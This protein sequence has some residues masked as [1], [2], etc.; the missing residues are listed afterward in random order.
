MKAIDKLSDRHVLALARFVTACE[1]IRGTRRWRAQLADCAQRSNYP[2]FATQTDATSL[3]ELHIR[4]VAFP[5]SLKTQ[6][7]I[8]AGNAVAREWKE[9]LDISESS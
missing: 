8:E 9:T 2:P 5:C 3:R 7:V 6:D 4:R 1:R